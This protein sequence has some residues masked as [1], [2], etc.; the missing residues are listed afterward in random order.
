VHYV[1]LVGAA[2]AL[3]SPRSELTY[4]FAILDDDSINAYS[5]PGGYIFIT[6]GALLFA[7]DEAEL[8]AILAHEIAHITQRH[9]V[10]ELNIR[11]R[12]S[13]GLS[14]L[15]RLLG[16]SADTTRAALGQAVDQAMEIFFNK[17]YR[18]EDE[19]EADR[20][21]LLLLAQSGYEPT[22]L[23]RYLT[24]AEQ[25]KASNTEQTAHTHP[26]SDKRFDSI[27]KLIKEEGLTDTQF[28]NE[29]QRFD[30]YVKTK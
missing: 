23:L 10:K 16:G 3:H 12:D 25:A 26:A 22:S 29:K 17:G 21:A 18:I 4:Y 11:A 9:I 19:L 27:Q 6:K 1:N 30:H 5:A 8:A 15:T 24:R 13:S 7:N 20:I 2:L 28:Y 14:G